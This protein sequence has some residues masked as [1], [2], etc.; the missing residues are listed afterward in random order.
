MVPSTSTGKRIQ[1]A[2]VPTQFR[3]ASPAIQLLTDLALDVPLP[4]LYTELLQSPSKQSYIPPALSRTL[5]SILLRAASHAEADAVYEALL[6]VVALPEPSP[7]ACLGFSAEG[8]AKENLTGVLC[9]LVLCAAREEPLLVSG[10]VLRFYSEA[11]HGAADADEYHA[12]L[13]ERRDVMEAGEVLKEVRVTNLAH[14]LEIVAKT[15]EKG[16]KT[17]QR[18][19]NGVKGTASFVNPLV[20][21]LPTKLHLLNEG[22][23]KGLRRL[24]QAYLGIMGEAGRGDMVTKLVGSFMGLAAEDVGKLPE[25]MEFVADADIR[26]RVCRVCLVQR[27]KVKDQLEAKFGVAVLE[28]YLRVSPRE[29]RAVRAVPLL[30]GGLITSWIEIARADEFRMENFGPVLKR[31]APLSKKIAS[32]FD[33]SKADVGFFR[34]AMLALSNLVL[35]AK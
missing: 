18:L 3:D 21:V 8:V 23:V 14:M 16:G 20:T 34:T 22:L 35:A 5:I 26:F 28:K 19:M 33:A 27:F 32:D 2:P 31:W 24:Y 17:T 11:G 9:E 29:N 30:L 12:A 10:E 1:A 25:Y 15:F 6:A 4:W 7:C 13:A